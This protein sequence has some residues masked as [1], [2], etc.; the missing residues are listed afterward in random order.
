MN[1]AIIYLKL[2]LEMQDASFD[3]SEKKEPRNIWKA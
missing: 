1:L 2:L 3:I